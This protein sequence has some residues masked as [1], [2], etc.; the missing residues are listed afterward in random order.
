M[1]CVGGTDGTEKSICR[2]KCLYNIKEVWK[3][4][5]HFVAVRGSLL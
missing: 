2:K 5:V 4:M 1:K 3:N